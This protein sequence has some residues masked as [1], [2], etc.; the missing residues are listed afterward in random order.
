MNLARGVSEILA[1]VGWPVPLD[2]A[3]GQKAEMVAH[4]YLSASYRG[5]VH[6]AAPKLAQA[7]PE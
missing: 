3:S 6:S 5:E 2:P 1:T 7:F 4:V